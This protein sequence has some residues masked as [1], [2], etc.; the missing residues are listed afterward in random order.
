MKVKFLD[1]SGETLHEKEEADIQVLINVLKEDTKVNIFR[2]EDNYFYGYYSS[3][4]L[5]IDLS[6]EDNPKEELFIY[7]NSI[8]KK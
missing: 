7:L 2:S 3:H 6:E 8:D 4:L 5:N 1:D